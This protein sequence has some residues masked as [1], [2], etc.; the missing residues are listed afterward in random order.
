MINKIEL[1]FKDIKFI[2]SANKKGYY[3]GWAGHGN[4]GDEILHDVIVD[5]L[6]KDLALYDKS[7]LSRAVNL[8]LRRR[9]LIFDCFILGGGTLIG[10]P[11]Y[12]KKLEQYPAPLKIAFGC[13]VMNP[14]YWMQVPSYVDLRSE[15]VSQLNAFDY[16]SVRGPISKQLLS[17]WGVKKQI[18]VIGDP[19]LY[20]SDTEVIQKKGQK[21]LGVNLGVSRGQVWGGDEDIV[22]HD[23]VK[24]LRVLKGKGWSFKFFPVWQ[25]DMAYIRKAADL[26]GESSPYIIED[27]LNIDT[28]MRELRSVD[29]FLG[30]KLHAVILAACTYTPIV[31]IEY[32]PKCRDFMESINL[33]RNNIRCDQIFENKII[34]IVQK[35]YDSLNKSQMFLYSKIKIFKDIIHNASLDV[36][37][38]CCYK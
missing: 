3:C 4:L 17:D 38:L 31:M 26:L 11:L 24:E 15:W 10:R 27:F 19:V 16:I 20:M 34:D 18:H 22:L 7:Y 28:F 9:H 37:K 32:R 33:G 25:T 1:L 29:V 6:G 36:I 30:E 5:L 23:V 13:G 14:E 35:E 8:Y 21:I 2:F 12:L